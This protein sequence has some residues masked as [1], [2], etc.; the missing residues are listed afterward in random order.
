[1]LT[2]AI[3]TAIIWVKNGETILR[4]EVFAYAYSI[5]D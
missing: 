5:F 2:Q 4:M 3:L 1:M